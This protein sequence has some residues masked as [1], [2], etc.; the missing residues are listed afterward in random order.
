MRSAGEGTGT[1]T[2]PNEAGSE[3]CRTPRM[4]AAKSGKDG[5]GGDCSRGRYGEEP[6]G[7]CNRGRYG[8]EPTG[9]PTGDC[10]P[11]GPCPG[12]ASSRRPND[13]L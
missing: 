10:K 9:E 5:S 2:I 3:A 12:F 8:G 11:L 7:D 4:M 1:G 6:A 13:A